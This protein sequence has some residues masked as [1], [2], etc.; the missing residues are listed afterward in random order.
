MV[1][2]KIE[3]VCNTADYVIFLPVKNTRLKKT[4]FIVQYFEEALIDFFSKKIGRQTPH[5]QMGGSTTTTAPTALPTANPSVS[6]TTCMYKR[7][8]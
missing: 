6:A 3:R 5:P 7:K 4:T 1:V 2:I 8:H